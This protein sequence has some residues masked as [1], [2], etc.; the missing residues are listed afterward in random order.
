[1]TRTDILR[2]LT[3]VIAAAAMALRAT[4]RR[5]IRT[6]RRA[7]ADRPQNAKPL[8][9]R[10]PLARLRFRRLCHAGVIVQVSDGWCY[11]DLDAFAQY[12]RARRRRALV[13]LAVMLP[14]IGLFWWF[15][16]S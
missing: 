10:S 7:G 2:L 11:L 12:R 5:L 13:V 3:L 16:G 6:L 4:D 9:V 1:V 14:A 8:M 15:I